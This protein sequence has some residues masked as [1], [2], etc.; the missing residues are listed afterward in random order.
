MAD[1]KQVANEETDSDYL[2]DAI[3][4]YMKSPTW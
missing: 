1:A 3:D 4:Q 2:F